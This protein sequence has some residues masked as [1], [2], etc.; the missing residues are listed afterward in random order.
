M[1]QRHCFAAHTLPAV[2]ILPHPH[3]ITVLRLRFNRVLPAAIPNVT[4][5]YQPPLLHSLLGSCLGT[6]QPCDS[7]S[8]VACRART[9]A[10]RAAADTEQKGVTACRPGRARHGANQHASH[11]PDGGHPWPPGHPRH[12]ADHAEHSSGPPHGADARRRAAIDTAGSHSRHDAPRGCD[13][14]HNAR[15]GPGFDGDDA[16]QRTRRPH[17]RDVRHPRHSAGRCGRGGLQGELVQE[18]RRGRGACLRPSEESPMGVGTR[19]CPWNSASPCCGRTLS[20]MSPRARTHRG[21][22]IIAAAEAYHVHASSPVTALF[23]WQLSLTG[24]AM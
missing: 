4:H 12:G 16:W 9:H 6:S 24:L 15:R 3:H 1:P 20:C 18:L 13:T 8:G 22:L 19:I 11:P 2:P 10:H 17:A 5:A 7:S 21:L 14:G 23:V